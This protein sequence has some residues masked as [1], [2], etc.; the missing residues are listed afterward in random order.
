MF[1]SAIPA[2]LAAVSVPW[3]WAVVVGLRGWSWAV[4]CWIREW[5]GLDDVPEG[6]EIMIYGVDY[7]YC[8]SAWSFT[9]KVPITSPAS[10]DE[11]FQAMLEISK[12]F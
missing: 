8:L 7:Y 3:G 12:G 4:G 5:E 1:L 6:H 9:G 11:L 10:E 2:V